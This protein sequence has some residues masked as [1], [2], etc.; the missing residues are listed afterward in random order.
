MP[1]KDQQETSMRD[2]MEAAI[3]AIETDDDSAITTETA[4]TEDEQG[5]TSEDMFKDEVT[6]E[7]ETKAARETKA[8]EVSGEKPSTEPK[9]E[10]AE[11]A[12]DDTADKSGLEKA[13]ESWPPMAREG[14]A[15]L[16]D[17]VKAQISKRESEI[18]TALN[19]AKE[20][21]VAG[22]KFQSIADRYAQVFAAEGAPDPITGVEELIKTVTAL[23][24]GS[25]A[26]KA[27]KIAG[28]IQ[29]YG[30]DV[31]TLDDILS[32]EVSGRGQQPPP[33]DPRVESLITNLENEK[34]QTMFRR[35]QAAI[36]EVQQ[37]K[38][39]VEFY[40]AVANDMADMVELAD[41][42][43]YVMPLQEAYDKCCALNAEVSQVMSKRAAEKALLGDKTTLDAKRN[44]SSSIRGV[45]G[46]DVSTDKS[47]MSMRDIMSEAW[48]AQQG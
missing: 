33:L 36:T 31:E 3:A 28:F 13:P 32:G 11:S 8:E 37:F 17:A 29:H 15:D 24:M 34:R 5:I 45:I 26:Q 41:K 39:S 38:S 2:D 27:A 22:A 12:T 40:D 18:N 10:S 7:T 20:H 48:N 16:P 35:N 14:W 47:D 44:A 25:P 42:R 4:A 46:G 23:Q 30:V 21:R 19:D 9:S 6:E 1:P 43:G